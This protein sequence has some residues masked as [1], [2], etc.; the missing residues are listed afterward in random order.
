MVKIL[1]IILHL[2]F[3]ITCRVQTFKPINGLGTKKKKRKITFRIK[4]VILK[5]YFNIF[6]IWLLTVWNTFE[7]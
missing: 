3:E 6:Y 2:W 1:F 5:G 4:Q 7:I